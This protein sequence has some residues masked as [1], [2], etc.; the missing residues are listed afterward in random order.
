MLV[1][2]SA[3]TCPWCG[4]STEVEVEPD[5]AEQE[6]IEDCQVCCHPIRVVV[7]LDPETGE[8]LG[9]SGDRAD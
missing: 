3:L 6:Y 4:E 5:L 7:T 9:L 2:E 8:L 1:T